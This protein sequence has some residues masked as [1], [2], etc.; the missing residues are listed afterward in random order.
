MTLYQELKAAGVPLDSHESDLYFKHTREAI[1][2]LRR[3]PVE[4]KASKS[5]R[6]ELDG[7]S[8]VE[9]PFAFSPFW[10]DRP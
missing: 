2:I 7:D 8:W 5:F 6:S 4:C 9:V 1:D 3:Y 10:E